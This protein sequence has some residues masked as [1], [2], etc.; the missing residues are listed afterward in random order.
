[1]VYYE[2][3]IS[4]FV[5]VYFKICQVRKHLLNFFN[6]SQN[7]LERVLTNIQRS[8]WLQLEVGLCVSEDG[9]DLIGVEV[10]FFELFELG[11]TGANEVEVLDISFT[12]VDGRG[13][14]RNVFE[15][16]E[17]FIDNVH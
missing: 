14:E 10:K 16:L 6:A 5:Q 2:I 17:Q 3:D 1:M 11:K 7:I 4:F 13:V 9:C 15:E 8:H 12:E